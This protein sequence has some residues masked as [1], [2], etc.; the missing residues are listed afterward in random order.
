VVRGN[1]SNGLV[2]WYSHAPHYLEKLVLSLLPRLTTY[3]AKSMVLSML[4]IASCCN[5]GQEEYIVEFNFTSSFLCDGFM[6]PLHFHL[7]YSQLHH[8]PYKI[9]LMNFGGRS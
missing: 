8:L 5:K 7:Y 2:L 6:I 1:K 4:S 9:E 3:I